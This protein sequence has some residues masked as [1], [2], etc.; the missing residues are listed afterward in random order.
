MCERVT[1][2]LYPDVDE[3]GVFWCGRVSH[4]PHLSP[5]TGPVAGTRWESSISGF[6]DPEE[7]FERLLRVA[8]AVDASFDLPTR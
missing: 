3:E 5:I 7:C 1:Y 6:Q 4:S 8:A 2:T